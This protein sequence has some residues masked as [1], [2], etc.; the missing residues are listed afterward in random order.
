MGKSS[1]NEPFSMAMLNNQM[2]DGV[3]WYIIPSI[4]IHLL[5]SGV[6]TTDQWVKWFI[7]ESF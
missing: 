4:I 6:S 2:V 1:V 7:L 3:S 5:V